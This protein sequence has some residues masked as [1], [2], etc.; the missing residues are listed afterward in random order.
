MTDTEQFIRQF[1]IREEKL[2]ARLPEGHVLPTRLYLWRTWIQD[3]TIYLNEL[4]D[5][6]D[7]HDNPD[8]HALFAGES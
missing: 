3:S 1:T 2:L 7:Q 5:H 8:E 6:V 4:R